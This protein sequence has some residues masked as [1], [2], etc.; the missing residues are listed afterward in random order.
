[1]LHEG[2]QID[3]RGR[4]RRVRRTKAR[5]SCGLRRT[6][7]GVTSSPDIP[8]VLIAPPA[9]PV[10]SYPRTR[11]AGRPQVTAVVCSDATTENQARDLVPG[12]P[13]AS[14]ALTG[15]TRDTSGAV[16]R[17]GRGG[18]HREPRW[19]R[20]VARCPGGAELVFDQ[21]EALMRHRHQ[22]GRSDSRQGR[23]R[24]PRDVNSKAMPA[25]ARQLRLRNI[26]GRDRD[27][28]PE[29]GLGG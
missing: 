20:R 16:C 19:Q 3:V 21:A 28:C 9:D 10:S 13:A 1:M 6:M 18:C 23:A 27:R 11:S 25:I 4:G 14:W 17:A 8:A 12:E 15:S 7:T 26:A 29:D 24:T 2:A 22:L 5:G